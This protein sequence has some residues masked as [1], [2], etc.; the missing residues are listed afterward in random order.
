MAHEW[1]IYST[2]TSWP[3]LPRCVRVQESLCFL[4]DTIT[5]SR[6]LP[7]SSSY[8]Y[9]M[10]RQYGCGRQTQFTTRTVLLH[11]RTCTCTMKQWQTAE[12]R[13]ISNPTFPRLIRDW[14]LRTFRYMCERVYLLFFVFDCICLLY[15]CLVSLYS[16]TYKCCEAGRRKNVLRSEE[17]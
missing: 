13:L 12:K 17:R 6:A 8:A 9:T 3:Q 1:M 5:L 16:Y 14:A 2:R 10:Q 7:L 11:T 4:L 15:L